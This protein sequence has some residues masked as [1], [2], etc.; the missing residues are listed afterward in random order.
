MG[1]AELLTNKYAPKKI[2][3][4]IGNDESR[5]YV[6]RWMLNWLAKNKRRPLLIFGPPGVGKTCTAYALAAQYDLEI[7]EFGSSELRNK[8]RV[9]QVVGVAADTGTLSG[10]MRMILIDDVDIFI[11]KKDTGGLGAVV[12]I[13]KEANCPIIL[14]ATD[15][16]D[17]KLAPIRLECDRVEYKKV[18]RASIKKFLAEIAKKEKMDADEKK[19]SE[20]AENSGGDVRS[21]LIDLQAM[22]PSMREREE[23]IFWRVRT[24]FKSTTYTEAKEALKGDVDYE[25]LNLWIEENIPEEYER[26][27]DLLRAFFWLSR[28]DVFFGRTGNGSWMMLKYA[29]DLMSAGVAL[30]KSEPYRKFTKYQFPSYLRKMGESVARRALIKA[31]GKKIGSVTH[32]NANEARSYFGLL[33]GLKPELLKEFYDLEDEEIAFLKEFAK[34]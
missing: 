13:I 12:K 2:E 29:L 18:S 21:A 25:L 9:E 27:G 20:I 1:G 32:T 28:S 17:K 34:A 16:W 19:I 11:G 33:A 8:E 24:I 31:V 23:D 15:I 5:E 3:E 26:S 22:R 4:I 7:M 10:R 6:K 30:A 14:T